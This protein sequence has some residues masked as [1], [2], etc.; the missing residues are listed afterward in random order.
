MGAINPEIA[1]AE[2]VAP[3][4]SKKRPAYAH[5]FRRFKPGIS[6][7]MAP[8]SLATPI[9]AMKYFGYPRPVIIVTASGAI[10]ISGMAEKIINPANKMVTIQYH[11]L[12]FF[13]SHVF[14]S[15]KSKRPQ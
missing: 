15:G 10:V 3:I 13:I 7:V 14:W 5:S 1:M 11:V 2:Y 6:M 4:R 8:S 9:K 12:V